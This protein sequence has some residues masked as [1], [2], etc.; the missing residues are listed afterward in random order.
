MKKKAGWI[1]GSSAC[2]YFFEALSFLCFFLIAMTCLLL[3]VFNHRAT[4][5][6]TVQTFDRP[7][8]NFLNSYSCILAAMSRARFGLHDG[9]DERTGRRACPGACQL[10]EWPPRPGGPQRGLK[11]RLIRVTI[12]SHARFSLAGY[13]TSTQWIIP[14]RKLQRR[15]KIRPFWIVE[16]AMKLPVIRL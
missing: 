13:L 2:P 6:L 16:A 7:P 3:F 9:G 8:G 12:A 5:Q 1:A 15:Y 4:N 11:D 10:E 14:L